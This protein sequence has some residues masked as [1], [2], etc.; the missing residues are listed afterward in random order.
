MSTKELSARLSALANRLTPAMDDPSVA[1]RLRLIAPGI[2]QLE[3]VVTGLESKV[4]AEAEHKR[5]SASKRKS[6]SH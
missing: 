6:R 3:S 1:H 2:A 4:A 5:A